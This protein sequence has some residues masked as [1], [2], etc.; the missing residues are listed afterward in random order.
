MQVT[1]SLEQNWLVQNFELFQ[2]Q[3]FTMS[4]IF[5]K[6]LAPFWKGFL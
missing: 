3:L 2:K 5:D 1:K 4:T 6:S